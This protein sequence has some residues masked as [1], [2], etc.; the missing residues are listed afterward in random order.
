METCAKKSANGDRRDGT[1]SVEDQIVVASTG[2]GLPGS[3]GKERTVSE[4]HLFRALDLSG[5]QRSSLRQDKGSVGMWMWPV[6]FFFSFGK[7]SV[8][9][10]LER[11]RHGAEVYRTKIASI[12]AV[13]D[14]S[15]ARISDIRREAGAI[16]DTDTLH[17]FPIVRDTHK[18]K[19]EKEEA[20]KPKT[21]LARL[22]PCK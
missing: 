11:S 22:A 3:A 16:A 17:T 4:Q 10:N 15:R 21:W 6:F 5:I 18:T 14:V 7:D 13:I 8:A 19:E 12:V 20:D 1:W 2:Q 9:R